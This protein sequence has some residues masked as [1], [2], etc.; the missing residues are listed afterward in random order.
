MRKLATIGAVLVA[1]GLASVPANAA[2]ISENINFNMTGFLDITGLPPATP[3]V[4][5][6]SGSFTLNFD[7]TLN[8][9][10]DF[11]PTDITVNALNLGGLTLDNPQVG[12]T[13]D[14]GSQDL[15]FGG[16]QND[17]DFVIEG[18]NDFVLSL[19]L[20]NLSDPAFILCNA[21]GIECGTQTGNGI[22]A[23]SG[24]TTSANSSSLFFLNAPESI[25][26]VPEPA[27]WA[28]FLVGFGAVGFMMR[29][30]LRKVVVPFA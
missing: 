21:P 30:P 13:Y 18:T 1:A 3:P 12:F 25:A 6:I 15:F 4:T 17:S 7:P 8:Y 5:G 14:A 10:S 26:D 27:T 11:N 28:M 9:D 20:T 29:R 2:T 19:N 22:Y 24:Y 16:I 23:A